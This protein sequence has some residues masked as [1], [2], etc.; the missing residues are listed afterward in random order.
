MTHLAIGDYYYQ[1]TFL[2]ELTKQFPNITLDIW[3]DDCRSRPKSWHA[4]RNQILCQ[5]LETESHINQIYPIA[6]SKQERKQIFEKVRQQNYDIVVFMAQTRTENFAQIARQISPDG[7]VV[8]TKAKPFQHW[9]KKTLAFGRLNGYFNLEETQ[10][11]THIND[12]YRDTFERLFS[13][14]FP[15]NLPIKPLEVPQEQLDKME[16]W[17]AIFKAQLST[18]NKVVLINHL[19][20]THR[21]DLPWENLVELITGLAKSHPEY[22]FILNLPPAEL[23][24]TRQKIAKTDEFQGIN[25]DVF[26]ATEHFFQLPSLLSLSDVV[27]TVETAV[28]HLASGLKTPQ[29]VLMRESAK[30]WCPL[31]AEQVLYGKSV[32][33]DIPVAKILQSFEKLSPI[34]QA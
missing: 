27:I 10:T 3:I 30:H 33:G 22:G 24:K 1:R 20:T 34:N 12:N 25:I 14:E 15:P 28:M 21:R 11:Q 17:V 23:D 2:D 8:G 32:V 6:A 5:W 16:Q 4:G 9:L 13:I 31:N 29:I 7:H 26:T 18:T 19:S